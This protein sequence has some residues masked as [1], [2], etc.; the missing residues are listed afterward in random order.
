[1]VEEVTHP[2]VYTVCMY[3]Q[4]VYSYTLYIYI[5]Y[6][7]PYIYVSLANT[8][9]LGTRQVSAWG[10]PSA[11]PPKH[12]GGGDNG[13]DGDTQAEPEPELQTEGACIYISTPSC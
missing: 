7:K 11:P 2:S 3:T 5:Q 10:V 13:D 9:R 1:M 8:G 12:S 4:Y 6:T